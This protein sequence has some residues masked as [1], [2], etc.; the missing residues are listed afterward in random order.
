MATPN[1]LSPT[2]V[3]IDAPSKVLFIGNSYSYYNNGIATL[4]SNLVRSSGLWNNSEFSTRQKTISGGRLAEHLAGF[5]ELLTRP[6][7]QS[8]DVVVM[9]EYSNGPIK[10]NSSATEFQQASGQLAKL[11]RAYHGTPVFFMTWAYKGN[12]AMVQQ[13]RDAYVAQ[14]NKL[15]MLVVPVG[16]AFAASQEKFPTIELYSKDVQGI[17]EHGQVVYQTLEKH[18]SLAGSYLAACVFYATLQ[19]KSPAGLSYTAG[20][21][22]EQAK[23]LQ[24]LGWQTS[25]QFLKMN[26]H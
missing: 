15:N 6:N 9:Q 26:S 20:L 4:Y 13:L 12:K 10:N 14:A 21:P 1:N 7:S 3:D 18:P 2:V 22:L 11:I 24:N 8:W 19:G 16:L 23:Q 17:D 5:S 25:Q